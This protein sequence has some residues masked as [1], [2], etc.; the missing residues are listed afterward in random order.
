M[1]SCTCHPRSG[2]VHRAYLTCA[3]T[4][5]CKAATRRSCWWTK[6]DEYKENQFANLA[7]DVCSSECR[8]QILSIVVCR[9]IGASTQH[10]LQPRGSQFIS[11]SLRQKGKKSKVS[12][13]FVC[14]INRIVLFLNST[15]NWKRWEQKWKICCTFV[16]GYASYWMNQTNP[17][18]MT[19]TSKQWLQICI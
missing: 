4:H 14:S 3:I 19:M 5:L 18:R 7:H 9:V 12:V 15:S 10:A 6:A 1:P 2:W 8:M 16:E 17:Q 11:L 13:W